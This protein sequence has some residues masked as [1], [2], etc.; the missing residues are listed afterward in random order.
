[1]PLSSASVP[2]SPTPSRSTSTCAAFWNW[3]CL[4]QM[5]ESV[6]HALVSFVQ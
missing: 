3:R 5:F 6:A 1:L 4:E 2:N